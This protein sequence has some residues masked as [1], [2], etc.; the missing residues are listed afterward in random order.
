MSR[1]VRDYIRDTV[2]LVKDNISFSYARESD[3]NAIKGKTFPAVL[4]KP[5]EYKPVRTDYTT[6][7]E[8]DVTLL[9][10]SLDSMQGAEEETQ[11]ILDE[12]DE[13]VTKFLALINLRSL[14]VEDD[15]EDSVTSDKIVISSESI[16]PRIKFTSD[17]VTGYEVNFTL[18]VPDTLNYCEVY[19]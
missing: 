15:P 3:F 2:L 4:L 13:L 7:K 18:E 14:S 19:D 1:L 16:R 9:F 5:L 8:Y 6:N 12:V 11:E 17:N 10:Y